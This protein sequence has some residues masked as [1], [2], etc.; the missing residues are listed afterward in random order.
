MLDHIYMLVSIPSKISVSSFMGYLIEKSA[1]MI[2]DRDVNLKYK[3]KNKRF[4]WGGESNSLSA[5]M[6]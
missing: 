4:F 1:L 5:I 3:F 2:F 6:T